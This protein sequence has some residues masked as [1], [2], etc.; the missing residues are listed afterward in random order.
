[1]YNSRTELLRM[2]RRYLSG[3]ATPEEKDFLEAYYSFFE[4]KQDFIGRLKAEEKKLLEQELE[5]G[6]WNAVKDQ[7][8]KSI[9]LLWAKIAT[10]AMVLLCLSIG[11]YN[12]IG[13][14]ESK[15]SIAKMPSPKEIPPGGNKAILTLANGKKIILNDASNGMIAQQEGSYVEKTQDGKIVYEVRPEEDGV[16]SSSL[17]YNTIEIPK[18][19][20]FQLILP[21]GTRVWMNSQSVLRYPTKFNNKERRVE[22]TGE[23]YF[24]VAHDE[25]LPF[26]VHS[27]YQELTVLGTR[28]NVKAYA[29]ES[30]ASTTLLQGKVEVSNLF[31]GKT[32]I[33]SP[34]NQSVITPDGAIAVST[35]NAEQAVAW[36]SGFFAFDNQDIETIMTIISR[37][38]NVDV[39]YK[40]VNKGIRLGGTFSRSSN[41]SELLKNLELIGDV[42]FKIDGRRVV[43]LK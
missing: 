8:K 36:K 38:Y 27:R 16:I 43:V 14:F 3:K 30:G 37:W 18:A 41:L 33:L 31:S 19:G 35:V 10:A 6:I 40:N 23:A 13:K 1:M 11:V 34:G 21:D 9:L 20:Q 15:E 17:E 32:K 22:L 29:D 26:R 5:A 7:E 24:E 2:V 28:F 12:F 39:E 42:H 25:R 4:K